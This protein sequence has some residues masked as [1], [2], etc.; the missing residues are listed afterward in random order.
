M[1]SEEF[2][3]PMGITQ[4]HLAHH[5]GWTQAKVSDIIRG[6]RGLTPQSALCL[7]D[8]FGVTP[9]FWLNAQ[10]AWDIWHAQQTHTKHPP[11]AG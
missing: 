7:A 11:I 3:K 9:Q 8:A 4:Q 10:Q 2:M 5:L 6:R 1:L